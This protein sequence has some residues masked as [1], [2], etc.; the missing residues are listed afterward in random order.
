MH[1]EMDFTV[2][3]LTFGFWPSYG[4]CEINLPLD[5]V[6]SIEI[7]KKFYSMKTEHRKLEWIYSAIMKSLMVIIN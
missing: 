3:V 5:L 6:K 7:F 1:L 4:F 2:E